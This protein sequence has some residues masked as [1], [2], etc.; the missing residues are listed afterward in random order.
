M[1]DLSKIVAKEFFHLENLL[2][3]SCILSKKTIEKSEL[4]QLVAYW[5]VQH[6]L[7]NKEY[8]IQLTDD[9]SVFL[10]S[11][12]DLI[13]YISEESNF[14]VKKIYTKMKNCIVKICNTLPIAV[15]SYTGA[16]IKYDFSEYNID[17]MHNLMQ[18]NLRKEK[19]SLK[20]FKK[21]MTKYN[22]NPYYL[23]NDNI[24]ALVFNNNS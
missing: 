4:D 23:D 5:F 20:K 12:D 3:D 2:V 14:L 19:K 10:L 7:T 22:L 24:K 17:M 13:S 11:K 21:L 18:K 1:K 8:L 15:L 9:S 6:I 16:S